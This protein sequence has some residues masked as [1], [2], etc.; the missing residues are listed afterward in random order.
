[1]NMDCNRENVKINMKHSHDVYILAILNRRINSFTTFLTNEQIAIRQ[2]SLAHYVSK[3]LNLFHLMTID[4]LGYWF[5]LS[6]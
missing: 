1:M 2:Q 5:I 6:L 3:K 4:V